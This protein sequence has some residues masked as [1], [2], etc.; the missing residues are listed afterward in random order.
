[1]EKFLASGWRPELN[2]GGEVDEI[3][4]LQSPFDFEF[5]G[6][7]GEWAGIGEDVPT[8]DGAGGMREWDWHELVE[9]G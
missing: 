9:F 5:G 8:G 7:I 1:M 3:E 4:E 2:E 6:Q